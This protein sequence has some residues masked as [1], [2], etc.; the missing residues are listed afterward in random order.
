MPASPRTRAPPSA[1]RADAGLNI[2]QAS[3]ATG[4]SAKAIR[5]YEALCLIPPVPRR[6]TG[7]YRVFSPVHLDAIRLIRQAQALGFTLREIRALGREDCS[8]DWPR[9]RAAAADK[10]RALEAEQQQLR[11]RQAAL[12]A[13]ERQLG[14]LLGAGDAVDVGAALRGPPPARAVADHRRPATVRR[15]QA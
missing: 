6:G 3:R 8:P 14:A 2:A 15:R 10:R 1:D 5:E 9:I 11:A 7:A 13:F 12:D 4:V